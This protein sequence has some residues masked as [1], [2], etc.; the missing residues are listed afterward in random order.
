MTLELRPKNIR[1]PWLRWGL[2]LVYLGLAGGALCVLF[3]VG[4]LLYYSR[5]LPDVEQLRSYSAPE[6]T[7]V[8]GRDGKLAAEFFRER[9]T[10]VPIAEVS[11]PM[12]EAILAAEDA[13]FY[14]HEGL[15]Y[16]GILRAALKNFRPGSRKQGASTITQQLV[17]NV[18]LSPEQTYSRKL[19]E[20]ILARRLEQELTK[21]EIFELYL[22]QIYFGHGRYGVAEAARFLFG[23]KP[24]AITL[25]QAAVLAAL[26]KNPAGY[27]PVRHRDRC[28]K[29][30]R[31]ILDQ[32]VDKGFIEPAAREAA[33]FPDLAASAFEDTVGDPTGYYA[34]H[35]RR[36]I[37][38]KYGDDKV[39]EDGLRVR[40]AMDLKLQAA[41]G[42]AVRTGL[43]QVDRRTGYRGPWIRGQRSA[44]DL[45]QALTAALG[46][47][48]EGLGLTL[49]GLPPPERG[50]ELAALL[51]AARPLRLEPGTTYL[52][53]VAAIDAKAGKHRHRKGK[54]VLDLGG[55]R[56]ELHHAGLAWARKKRGARRPTNVSQ[57]VQVGDLI[58]ARLTAVPADGNPGTAE[59]YQRPIVQGAL[60]AIDPA[61]REVV[62]MV[63]GYDFGQSP[64]IRAVQAR[65]QPGSSIKPL[66]YG[67]AMALKNYSPATIVD[68]SPEVY[69]NALRGSSWRPKNFDGNFR[70]P[71]RLR[72]ALTHS[73]NMVSIKILRDVGVKPFHE[74]ARKMG[75]ET[76][77]PGNLSLALGSADLTPLELTNAYTSIAAGGRAQAPLLVKEV[78]DREGNTLWKPERLAPRQAMKPAT[79]YVLASMMGSVIA[80]GTGKRA[81]A[82]GRPAAGKTGTSNRARNTWFVGFTPDL[83]CG[84]WVGRDDNKPLWGE[85]GGSAA[86]P[87]WTAFMQ[88]AHQGKPIR[89]FGQP[90]GVTVMRIDPASGLLP[91]PGQTDTLEEV[92]A[93]GTEPTQTAP[94]D[95]GA[96]PLAP[97]EDSSL[98]FLM[99]DKDKDIRD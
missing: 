55:G 51:G 29:R 46:E 67:S 25:E 65:R 42:E 98:K 68:D 69:K 14:E 80:E 27:S 84:V 11:Q 88:R 90:P 91:R 54:A 2:R 79:A 28:A 3:L 30:W 85:A 21:D 94:E 39:L 12:R 89:A 7:R 17:K 47:R 32:M 72:T 92:F 53:V 63:G 75:I 45:Q 82:L 74:F 70:G 5:G 48:P 52:A 97:P 15:D 37:A 18:L 4:A 76:E 43:E 77:L 6:A 41:A 50:T 71:L 20:W 58:E 36:F 83:V 49:E 35:V 33:R 60:V 23:V 9:R 19:K 56:A 86:C 22:N 93:E 40:C 61:T 62:A 78:E 87:I 31:W 26:P 1:S 95:G 24:S 13:D 44:A 73:V 81:R 34:E 59:L 64:F 8:L 38:E 57:V 66:V 96:A 10:D 99:Q 16:W